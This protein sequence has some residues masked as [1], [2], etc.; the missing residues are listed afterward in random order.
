VRVVACASGGAFNAGSSAKQARIAPLR[1]AGAS[2]DSPADEEAPKAA[3]PAVGG[4][5]GSGAAA[6]RACFPAFDVGT[7]L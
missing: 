2:A 6:L 4:G 7:P 1:A 5:S 3:T